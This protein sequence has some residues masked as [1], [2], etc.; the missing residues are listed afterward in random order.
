MWAW[1][2]CEPSCCGLFW[3]WVVLA[4]VPTRQYDSELGLLPNLVRGNPLYNPKHPDHCIWASFQ[5]Q[6]AS[7]KSKVLA[8]NMLVNSDCI[9]TCSIRIICS[10]RCSFAPCSPVYDA[11]N[12][13]LVAVENQQHSIHF[14]LYF[15]A[16]WWRL[17]WLEFVQWEMKERIKVYISL[18]NHV[19]I[20][21]DN[22]YLI[23]AKDVGTVRRNS[24]P[25]STRLETHGL[26]S[27]P[28]NNLVLVDQLRLLG[29][30]WS[31]PGPSDQFQP[32]PKPGNPEPLLTLLLW[33][34]QA[35]VQWRISRCQDE[36][37]WL[38]G[39]SR[40]GIL[41]GYFSGTLED[42]R[43]GDSVE[44]FGEVLGLF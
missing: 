15:T 32:G 30:S 4:K 39:C 34:I 10:F 9:S 7:R 27:C 12:I 17:I 16:T 22:K 38:D 14:L 36:I 42:E 28:G 18:I 11:I 43:M 35:A 44:C 29:S 31:R 24:S 8:R 41:G 33:S 1:S 23:A 20:W 25:D 3:S 2:H 26:M 21:S 40:I 5:P 6:S 19:V 37:Y 13:S